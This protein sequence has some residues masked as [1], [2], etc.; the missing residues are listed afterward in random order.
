MPRNAPQI[1][2][3]GRY[4]SLSSQGHLQ[5][6]LRASVTGHEA[7]PCNSI[8][9]RAA[10][11]EILQQYYLEPF[12]AVLKFIY[13]LVLPAPLAVLRE[14]LLASPSAWLKLQQLAC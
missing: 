2:E 14:S 1:P 7:C 9:L 6:S 12:Q 11:S 8:C 4:E 13:A 3:A 5:C 10:Y